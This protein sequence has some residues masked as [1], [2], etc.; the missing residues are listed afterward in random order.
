MRISFVVGIAVIEGSEVVD[1]VVLDHGGEA[2]VQ[3]AICQASIEFQSRKSQSLVTLK[4]GKDA[5]RKV[6]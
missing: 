1:Q 4:D 2:M 5:L 6:D 3:L